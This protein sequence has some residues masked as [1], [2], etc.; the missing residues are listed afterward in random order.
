VAIEPM[1]IDEIPMVCKGAIVVPLELEL[2]VVVES[3]DAGA[4]VVDA[5]IE[6]VDINVEG[7]D[8]DA[9]VIDTKVEVAE[10]DAD[11]NAKVEVAEADADVN[12]KVEVVDADAE[13]IGVSEGIKVDD[14]EVVMAVGIDDTVLEVDS[15]ERTEVVDAELL[16]PDDDIES[17]A[18][19][20]DEPDEVI[21]AVDILDA[22]VVRA[23]AC[24]TVSVDSEAVA[25]EVAEEASELEESKLLD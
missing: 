3:D 11:A 18:V 7:V 8:A 13:I 4:K 1:G 10:A 17:N 23:D 15:A 20:I 21:V 2:A 22:A 9:E 25:E 6:V 14:P 12:A 5:D 16:V 24:G 19:G